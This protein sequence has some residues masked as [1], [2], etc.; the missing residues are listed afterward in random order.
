[1]QAL[2]HCNVTRK[3][4]A[5]RQQYENIQGSD[6]IGSIADICEDTLNKVVIFSAMEKAGDRVQ[7]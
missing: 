6:L 2:E 5:I 4:Q 3:A 1:M 7:D